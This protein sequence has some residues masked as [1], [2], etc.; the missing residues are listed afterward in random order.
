MPK[1]KYINNINNYRGHHVHEAAGSGGFNK[2]VLSNLILNNHCFLS[3]YKVRMI[4]SSSVLNTD[5]NI[6][7]RIKRLDLNST[8]TKLE[9][10]EISDI[11][12]SE[13]EVKRL[14]DSLEDLKKLSSS[15]K[16][17][18]L[19]DSIPKTELSSFEESFPTVGKVKM[20]NETIER[21]AKLLSK[22]TGIDSDEV[23]DIILSEGIFKTINTIS[24]KL[25]VLNKISTLEN[26]S[27]SNKDQSEALENLDERL[28]GVE[29]QDESVNKKIV[30]VME[31]KAELDKGLDVS[32]LALDR[33]IKNQANIDL[34]VSGMLVV[35]PIFAY[36]G[37]LKTYSTAIMPKV[38]V[39]TSSTEYLKI[40]NERAR[41][42]AKFN[43]VAIPGLAAYYIVKLR[44]YKAF[45][46]LSS[47]LG[48]NSGTNTSAV[49]M[50]ILNSSLN[51]TKISSVNK[52]SINNNTNNNNNNKF[53]W[54]S[55]LCI[56]IILMIKYLSPSLY[57]YI[58][59][60]ISID[61]YWI[62]Y[63]LLIWLI[64]W[65]IHYILEFYFFYSFLHK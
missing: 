11:C 58:I 53:K 55:L 37:L 44:Y 17:K 56:F 63:S 40:M 2:F 47:I 28:T 24:N 36:R 34:L 27:G 41:V 12:L 1:I 26:E 16:E 6:E 38:P 29:N 59:N 9:D 32:I 25:D 65:L 15:N 5:K 21:T 42:V 18:S 46:P 45:T 19:L 54:L 7:D 14:Q 62:K 39:T 35:S 50:F 57:D 13:G 20:D 48:D 31:I 30:D 64:G 22:I 8:N 23:K 43:K 52:N 61:P 60:L 4:H 3:L 33:F 49:N 10:T 51:T